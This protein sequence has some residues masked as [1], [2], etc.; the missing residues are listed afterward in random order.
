MPVAVVE[1]L[2]F[3]CVQHSAASQGHVFLVLVDRVFT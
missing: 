3:G 1:Q 2:G